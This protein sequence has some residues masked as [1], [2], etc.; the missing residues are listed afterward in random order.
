MFR[1]RDWD[2]VESEIK[3]GNNEVAFY[4]I[5]DGKQ[6]LNAIISFMS[7]EFTDSY[8]NYYSDLSDSA[9]YKFGNHQLFSY[10]ELTENTTDQETLAQF[11][12]V[13]FAGV[14]QSK[15]HIE[16]VKNLS[17]HFPIEAEIVK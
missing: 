15:E 2:W 13:N 10:I 17:N 1:R 12:K 16:Y 11:L 3:N 6:R 5:V 7:D 4:D 9:Q 14:L 8:G